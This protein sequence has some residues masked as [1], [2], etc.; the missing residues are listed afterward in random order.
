MVKAKLTVKR[1]EENA[2]LWPAHRKAEIVFARQ[3]DGSD[4]VFAV[5][6][7]GNILTGES[8]E[9]AI[10]AGVAEEVTE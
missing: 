3:A 6:G 10:A 2:T 5:Y 9:S 8:A 7:R 4:E 1:W